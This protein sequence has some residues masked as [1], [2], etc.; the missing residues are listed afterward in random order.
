[1]MHKI[2]LRKKELFKKPITRKQLIKK[3][4][5]L[6]SA[7]IKVDLFPKTKKVIVH[8]DYMNN[9]IIYE[10]FDLSFES[11]NRITFKLKNAFAK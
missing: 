11:E 8:S 3:I 9:Y 2:L 1:M 6:E 7:E 5:L 10:P 4:E